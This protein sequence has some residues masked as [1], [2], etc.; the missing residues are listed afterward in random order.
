MLLNVHSIV[1]SIIPSWTEKLLIDK[2]KIIGIIMIGLVNY[3]QRIHYQTT[4]GQRPRG[5]V[6]RVEYRFTGLNHQS[7]QNFDEYNLS[8]LL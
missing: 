1:V 8:V 2:L 3:I 6:L 4:S 5:I 7:I